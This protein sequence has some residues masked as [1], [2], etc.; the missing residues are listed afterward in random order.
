MKKQNFKKGQKANKR[1]T[2]KREANVIINNTK[3]SFKMY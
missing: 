2:N 3:Y 1:F